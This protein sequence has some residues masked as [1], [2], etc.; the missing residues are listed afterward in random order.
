MPMLPL[1]NPDGPQ[2]PRLRHRLVLRWDCA[3]V[4]GL[5]TQEDKEPGKT[6]AAHVYPK[7]V[8]P[9]F[10]VDNEGGN[11]GANVGREDDGARPD[12][13][14]AWMLVEKEEVADPHKATL[15]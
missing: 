5:V 4:D 1:F 8:R 7:S 15:C 12:V 6:S 10:L 13:D 2:H 9:W 14:L 3:V 11:E